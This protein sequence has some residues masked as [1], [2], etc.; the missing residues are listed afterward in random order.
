MLHPHLRSWDMGDDRKSKVPNTNEFPLQSGWD[1][2]W[3]QA[4]ALGHLEGAWNTVTA[5]L[6]LQKPTEGSVRISPGRFYATGLTQ[7]QLERFG[8]SGLG[9]PRDPPGVTGRGSA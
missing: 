1:Q 6:C 8:I 2:P 4:E 9:T 7:N 3:R 5:L